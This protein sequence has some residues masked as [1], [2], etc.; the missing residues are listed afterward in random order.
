MNFG[1]E[2][3][4]MEFK[5]STSEMQEAMV[6]MCAMLNKHGRGTILFGVAPNGELLGL[7]VAQ[8]TLRN[9]SMRVYESITP[10]IIPSVNAVSAEGKE[11]IEVT[12]KG[13]ERPYSC[14][15]TYYI[16][17]ADEDRL[18]PAGE[19]RQMFE[20]GK[21]DTWDSRL[22]GLGMDEIDVRSLK[23]FYD[24]AI[25]SGRLKDP[26]FEPNRL[27]EKLGL[28]KDGELTNAAVLLF[29]KNGPITLKMAVFA[30]EEKLTFIDINRIEGNI[31]SLL[32]EANS[33]I[34]KNIHWAAEFDGRKR[35]EIPEI[36]LKAAREIV[37]NSFVHARYGT[38]TEHEIDI[39]PGSVRIYN[40]GEFPIGYTPEEFASESLPPVVRNPLILKTLFLS[41]DVESY[42]S[43]FKRVYDECSKTGV[44]T[45]YKMLRDGFS[46][47]F[48]R[49]AQ[50]EEGKQP[51]PLGE[52]ESSVLEI[53]KTD[54]SITAE[55]IA[56]LSGKSQS[57]VMRMLR[58][59]REKGLID[60]VGGT[61]G[62]WKLNI[63]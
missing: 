60:R 33:Y 2:D 49:K 1:R 25:A 24:K 48:A 61:K 43:G 55:E 56:A 3:E 10:R 57:T 8:D 58:K 15:G 28:A 35:I 37:C 26:D 29:S 21:N 13:E 22:S 5:K 12:F 23:S 45:S 34:S 17:S 46:F 19:L 54:P 4:T 31:M 40:P 6:S 32:D 47:E 11:F 42:G 44:K 30:T 18:L 51:N 41:E 52:K 62:Y 14:K 9:I 36:P 63:D 50:K 7:D 38:R 59:L 53:L 16:R 27:L 20:Y 39:H